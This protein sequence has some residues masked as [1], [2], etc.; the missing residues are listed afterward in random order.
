[1]LADYPGYVPDRLN[2]VLELAA[3]QLEGRVVRQVR[4]DNFNPYVEY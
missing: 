4:P 3:K 2:V 1:M